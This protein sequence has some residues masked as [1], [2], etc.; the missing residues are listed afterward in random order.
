MQCESCLQAC[1]F[2]AAHEHATKADAEVRHPWLM[3]SVMLSSCCMHKD[4]GIE[5]GPHRVA[6]PNRL[7]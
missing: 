5:P 4:L 1:C 2:G 3:F 6:I 7:A